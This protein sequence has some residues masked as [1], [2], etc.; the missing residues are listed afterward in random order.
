MNE[1]LS[2]TG[3]AGGARA[4]DSELKEVLQYNPSYVLC[5]VA[6]QFARTV[7]LGN[8]GDGVACTDSSSFWGQIVALADDTDF[9]WPV[10][11]Q[12]SVS[13]VRN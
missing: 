2:D 13:S 3:T 11:Q 7:W 4:S 8:P 12:N 1:C 5:I 10:W 6:E 9:V